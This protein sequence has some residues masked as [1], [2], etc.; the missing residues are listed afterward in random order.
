M[1]VYDAFDLGHAA[2]FLTDHLRD[3]EEGSGSGDRRLGMSNK[4]CFERK[5]DDR[6]PCSPCVLAH[7]DKFFQ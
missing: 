5:T 2:Q 6:R 4:P 1:T 3:I 7:I